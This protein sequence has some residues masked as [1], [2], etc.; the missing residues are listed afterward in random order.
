MPEPSMSPEQEANE[1][2]TNI[3][4]A[5]FDIQECVEWLK[6]RDVVQYYGNAVDREKLINGYIAA[7]QGVQEMQAALPPHRVKSTG[8]FAAFTF[9]SPPKWYTWAEK[10]FLCS[11]CKRRA[12]ILLT[13]EAQHDVI[14][15][16]GPSVLRIPISKAEMSNRILCY[17][18]LS[19]LAERTGLPESHLFYKMRPFTYL[20][21]GAWHLFGLLGLILSLIAIAINLFI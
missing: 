1:V 11:K 10:N 17:E 20:L 13:S 16:Q 18:C 3:S 2:I 7:A 19:E 21:R 15:I 12:G 8:T 9:R 14:P 4:D 6:G 5:L